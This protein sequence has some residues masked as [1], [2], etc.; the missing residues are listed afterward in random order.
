MPAVKGGRCYNG[1]HRDRGQIVHY[2]PAMPDG[3]NGDW[4][5]KA[6]CGVVPGRRSYGWS[7]SNKEVNCP[8]CLKK[9][10]AD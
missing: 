5:D 6:L 8:K 7:D 1:F 2:V 10:L 9:Y 3:S 4:F